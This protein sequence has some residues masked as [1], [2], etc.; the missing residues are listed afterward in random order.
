M[1]TTSLRLTELHV[2][3]GPLK[4]VPAVPEHDPLLRLGWAAWSVGHEPL[5]GRPCRLAGSSGLG[6]GLGRLAK[7]LAASKSDQSLERAPE[8]TIDDNADDWIDQTAGE[9]ETPAMRTRLSEWKRGSWQRWGSRT[10]QRENPPGTAMK[11][12]LPV[13]KRNR[14]RRRGRWR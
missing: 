9:S 12:R 1:E 13:W 11:T 6:E 14:W 2:V 3:S 4:L 8:V 7:Q 5:P 10:W